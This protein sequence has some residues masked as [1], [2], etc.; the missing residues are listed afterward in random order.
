MGKAV[1][2]YQFVSGLLPKI[3]VKVAGI[4]GSLDQLWIKARFEEAKL[5]DLSSQD[6]NS[7]SIQLKPDNNHYRR[8]S[9]SETLSRECYVC[10]RTLG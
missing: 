1:L 2:A 10:A 4:E 6:S 5:R 8:Y 7:K 9:H 3:Q